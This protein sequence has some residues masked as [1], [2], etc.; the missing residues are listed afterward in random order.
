MSSFLWRC[1]SH[2]LHASANKHPASFS[3]TCCSARD[4]SCIPRGISF[5]PKQKRPVTTGRV[6]TNTNHV[7]ST[8]T[9]VTSGAAAGNR[10]GGRGAEGAN[11][12]VG[13]WR[14]RKQAEAA[15]RLRHCA[16]PRQ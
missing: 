3:K 6:E 8:S 2:A 1:C 14:T 16:E 4:S 13:V 7:T 5:R 11:A 9:A 10:N 15:L 12:A